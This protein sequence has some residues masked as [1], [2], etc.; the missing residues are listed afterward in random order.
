M[1]FSPLILSLGLAF[2][3]GQVKDLGGPTITLQWDYPEQA[4][5][6][7][8]STNL[9]NWKLEGVVPTTIRASLPM[10]AP[11]KFYRVRGVNPLTLE[12][13][14]WSRKTQ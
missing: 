11:Q 8:S 4:T 6:V 7:W 13:S 10:D 12:V 5:E 9:V 14:D 1:D 3:L 2:S